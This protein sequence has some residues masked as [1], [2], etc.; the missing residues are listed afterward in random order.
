MEFCVSFTA[1]VDYTEQVG[2]NSGIVTFTA[3]ETAG[4]ERYSTIQIIDDNITEG[5]VAEFFTVTGSETV[6]FAMF[7][8]GLTSDT[9]RVEITDNDREF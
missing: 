5:D 3:G 6:L 7:S 9:V 2:V 4:T 1:G 8:N